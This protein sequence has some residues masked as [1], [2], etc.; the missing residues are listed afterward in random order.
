MEAKL[1]PPRG[2]EGPVAFDVKRKLPPLCIWHKGCIDGFT[3]AWVVQ[4]FFGTNVEFYPGVY[5]EPPPDVT[6][7]NV[8]MVDF[9]Y[10][11]D[12]IEKMRETARAILIIDHHKT[13]Q[14]DLSPYHPKATEV[15]GFPHFPNE[16]QCHAFFDMERSGAGLCW[17]FFFS[18]QPMPKFIQHVQDRDLWRF[19]LPGTREINTLAYSHEF[20][21][22]LWD[23]LAEQCEHEGAWNG[24]VV[25]GQGLDRQRAKDCAALIENGF[26]TQMIGGVVMPVINA[27]WFYA[28]DIG[29]ILA[30]QSPEKAAATYHDRGDGKRVFSLRSVDG[31]PDVSEIAK[32]YGG[33]GHAR[34]AGFT[35]VAPKTLEGEQD[36]QVEQPGDRPGDK[37]GEGASNEP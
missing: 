2:A 19:K 26:H 35:T 32:S 8:I 28:S 34:A 23:M 25:Q 16:G 37:S 14:E 4:K 18:G 3:S 13:A 31:G 29:N 7:R 1:L 30:S 20:D 22:K 21:F 17:D 12:V 6:D 15:A 11:R 24:L 9:S 10:K 5:Q 27:P 33:G 36:G